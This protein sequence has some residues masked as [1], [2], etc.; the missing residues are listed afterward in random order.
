MLHLLVQL[1]VVFL[2]FIVRYV[3]SAV[4]KIQNGRKSSVE[5]CPK[6]LLAE[7]EIQKVNSSKIQRQSEKKTHHFSALSLEHLILSVVCLP[8]PMYTPYLQNPI[9]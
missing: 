8:R 2:S 7:M 4:F 5:I 6:K 1:N 9:P 3:V